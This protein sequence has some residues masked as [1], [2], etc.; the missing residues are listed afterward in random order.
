[1]SV[2]HNVRSALRRLPLGYSADGRGLGIGLTA[3]LDAQRA[4]GA[5]P[6]E[7]DALPR[8]R[9]VAADSGERPARVR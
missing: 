3:A 1:M 9:G 6:M 2:R 4:R 5:E 7:Y 8:Q